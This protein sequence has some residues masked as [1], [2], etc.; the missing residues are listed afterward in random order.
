MAVFKVDVKAF[1]L[2]EV[3][4]DNAQ[5]ARYF[6]EDYVEQSLSPSEI[7]FGAWNDVQADEGETSKIVSTTGF[8]V[9]GVSEVEEA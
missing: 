3:D 1:I 5:E 4:A 7:E 8:Q 6:A 9:D 2:I